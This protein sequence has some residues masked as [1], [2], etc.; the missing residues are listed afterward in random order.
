MATGKKTEKLVKNLKI[1]IGLEE[2]K[3]QRENIEYT[4]F[5]FNVPK[6]LLAEF[7]DVA[8]L[9]HYSTAEAMKEAMR[10]F[11]DD[12]SPENYA[13]SKDWEIMYRGMFD[14]ILAASEDP[15]YKKLGIDPNAALQGS[16]K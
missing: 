1:G 9:N 3:I 14:G 7:N 6:K 5:K 2:E 13:S 11:I 4:S 10:R 12:A 15:K 16:Q 8:L